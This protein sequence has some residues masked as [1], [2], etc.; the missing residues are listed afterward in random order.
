M[1]ILSRLAVVAITAASVSTAAAAD[2]VF[3]QNFEVCWSPAYTKPQFLD[4]LRTSI[5]GTAGCLPPQSGNEN[6]ISYTIC[7]NA[8]GCGAGVAGCPVV[9]HAGN[10]TGDF[11]AG[12]F[13]GPGTIDA[14]AV[15]ITYMLDAFP[16]PGSCTLTLSAIVT[17][18]QLDYLMRV[19][20]SNGVHSD[21]FATPVVGIAS[22]SRSGCASIAS[23]IDPYVATAI[24][25][26]G[27]AA[28]LAIQP[29]LRANSVE[30]SICPINP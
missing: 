27:A 1:S 15:P 3:H 8:N 22:Y 30:K 25:N 28:G 13:S 17:Q 26:A 7:G 4:V 12:D 20:G 24:A 2:L 23:L 6:G 9:M 5:E 10:F 29:A 21:D 18:H 14:I 19:D 16:I 11:V